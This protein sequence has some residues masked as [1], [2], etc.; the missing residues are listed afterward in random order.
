MKKYHEPS[1]KRFQFITPRFCPFWGQIL[2]TK[3]NML[4]LYSPEFN[5]RQFK[6]LFLEIYTTGCSL[7][8]LRI[9]RKFIGLLTIGTSST[10][11]YGWVLFFFSFF[12]CNI[13]NP[14][15]I[16]RRHWFFLIVFF[17]CFRTV[18]GG[19]R[20]DRTFLRQQEHAQIHLISHQ[21]S[22]EN[23]FPTRSSC[24]RDT[25]ALFEIYTLELHSLTC[26]HANCSA[27]N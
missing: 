25:I 22:M 15:S 23:L 5:Y 10:V 14:L 20:Q 16:N 17:K 9:L 2:W 21:R 7:L 13:V 3:G 26:G 8:A 24:L 18:M 11:R 6:Y 4:D 19:C 1:G 27:S 12:F